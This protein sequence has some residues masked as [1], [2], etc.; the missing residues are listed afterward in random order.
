MTGGEAGGGVRYVIPEEVLTAHLQD[1]AVLLHLGTKR[2]FRLNATGAWIWQGLERGYSMDELLAHVCER[3]DVGAKEA[4][5]AIEAQLS[6]LRELGL[7]V[8]KEESPAESRLPS[9]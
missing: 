9:S 5:D 7:V 3:F 4:A 1:E 6:R 8:P 2:Y